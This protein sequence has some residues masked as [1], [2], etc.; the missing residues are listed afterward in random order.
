M[1]GALLHLI[2]FVKDSTKSLQDQFLV[3]DLV[4]I[5]QTRTLIAR[6]QPKAGATPHVRA[7]QLRSA[8][9]ADGI[10]PTTVTV[11]PFP[12]RPYSDRFVKRLG[13]EYRGVDSRV[14]T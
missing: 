2:A 14:N 9:G 4:T 10:S 3:G 5:E 12:S 1:L 6:N 13:A 7:D 11:L 8:R